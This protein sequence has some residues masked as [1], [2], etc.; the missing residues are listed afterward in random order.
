[1]NK[2]MQL[3]LESVIDAIVN[4]DTEA[5]KEAFHEYL[6]AKTQEILLGEKSDEDCEDMDDDKEDK[7]SDD[8]EDDKED[9]KSDDKEDK[10]SDKKAPPFVKKDKKADKEDK[11]DE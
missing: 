6:R 4:E 11:K 8:K 10:K 3:Q 7:K 1:M 9:K 2:Q 5:A